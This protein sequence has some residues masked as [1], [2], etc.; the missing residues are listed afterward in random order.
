[1]TPRRARAILWVT[2]FCGVLTT[3]R[4]VRATLAPDPGALFP[5][6]Q[7]PNSHEDSLAALLPPSLADDL[8]DAPIDPRAYIL[9]PGDRLSISEWGMVN[10]SRVVTV[11]PEGDVLVPGAGVTHVGGLTLDVG[12]AQLESFVRAQIRNSRV[13]VQLVGVRRFKVYVVGSVL[14]PQAI[15]ATA[16]LRVAEVIERAGGFSAEGARRGILLRHADSTSQRV[17][18]VAFSRVGRLDANPYVREGDVVLVP[19]RDA[20][21]LIEGA[22]G[23]TGTYDLMPDDTVGDLLALAA[24]A[25][26]GSELSR[27][28][29]YRFEGGD[30]P[31]GPF[32]L[33]ATTPEGRG[34]RLHD[35]D[36]FYLR[37]SS[38]WKRNVTAQIDGE[39]LFP[40]PYALRPGETLRDVLLRAGGFTPSADSSA[41][42]LE[43]QNLPTSATDE[44]Y[45]M[46]RIDQTQLRDED[47]A[48]WRLLRASRTGL[49]PINLATRPR[50]SDV[51]LM[52]GDHILVPRRASQ[53]RVMGEV[54]FPG[55]QDFHPASTVNSYVQLA[56]GFTGKADT[57][58]LRLSRLRAWHTFHASG[59]DL[60]EDGDVIWVTERPRGK[61][62]VF[63]R[64]TVG[65]LAQ[66]ATV[67]L[68]IHN[69]G[70]TS[71]K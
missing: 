5:E 52:S 4:C 17:D 13:A 70:S 66:L 55:L 30:R 12:R 40:G 69:T 32:Y 26:E 47:I 15:R 49:R 22:V 38:E 56:G 50:D 67:Y 63:I 43:R 29:Y 11:S 60:V 46:E 2:L 62:W 68:V 27:L 48:Y 8:A 53:V 21:V 64:D 6:T 19:P 59:D 16:T 1:M 58:H 35:G 51:I 61:S 9:G 18:L 10:G 25:L 33:D 20:S 37:R 7:R 42:S 34:F 24:G 54:R 71:A 31:T 45:A 3:P 28:E 14:K 36:R 65:V 23:H 57:G 39:V 44:T 41:I